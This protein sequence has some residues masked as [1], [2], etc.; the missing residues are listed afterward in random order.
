M[1]L[2]TLHRF[3]T[4]P[5]AAIAFVLA[6]PPVW[7]QIEEIVI[8]AR[9]QEERLQDVPIAVAAFTSEQLEERGARDMY[10]VTRFTP[11]FSFEK[12]NRYGVQ[13]GVSRPVIRGMSNILGEGN[14][15][16]FVDGIPYSDSILSFPFDIAERVE[17][18]KG[19]QAA[20]FGRATFSGAINLIT[21]KGGNKP[22]HTVSAR[23]AEYGDTELNLLSRGPLIDDKLF[24]MVH[25]RYYTM[26]GMY[27]NSLDGGRI[28]GEESNN[29]NASLEWRPRDGISAILSGGYTRDRDDLAAVTLQERF[30]NNCHLD[31]PRQYYCGAV[32]VAPAG[33]L[34]RAGLQGT[35]GLHR[36]ST[37]LSLQLTFDLPAGLTLVSNSGLFS[38]Q[39]EYGYDSTYQGATALGQT[40]VPGAPGYVRP[41][42][43][44][45]RNGGVMRNEVTDRDEWSTELRLQSDPTQRLSYM[46]GAYYYKSQRSLEE[47]HFLATAPTVF[48]G[49][50][51]VENLAAFASVDFD[52][53]DRWSATAELRYA[54]DTIGNDNAV[55]RP[56]SPLV[57]NTFDSVSPR[58][59]TTFKF[60]PENMVYANIA[61]GNKPGVINPDPRFPES[62]RFA[63]EEESWNYEIGTKNRFLNGGLMVNLSLYYIDWTNQQI[64]ASYTFPPP[65]GGT[66]SYIRNAGATEIKGAELEVEAAL[67]DNFTTGFTYSL[68]D[69]KFTS[70][71]DNEA[72]ELFGNASLKGNKLFGVPEQQASAYGKFTFAAGADRT[73]FVRG[74][75]SFTD[76]KFDQIFD[77]AHTGEQI[78]SN[79]SAGVENDH[80][81]LTF[82]VNN[83]FDDRTPS[84]VTRYVDQLNRNIPQYTNAN[85][86]QNNVPGSTTL[87]RAF[88]YP[89]PNKRQFGMTVKWKF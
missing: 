20:L 4:L 28:G 27:R 70:L 33:K 9:K 65:T 30:A 71:T 59:T 14:A 57:E 80:L 56:T 35:E 68:T 21:K 42:S 1:Q 55:A 48:S 82:F 85:P 78:L 77:L 74:D 29:F 45:V 22:E 34:D 38:T 64:T 18:I 32:Q 17:V 19:P 5:L 15:Q 46:I 86:A 89:L 54:E 16:V 13:G 79:L 2:P 69:A 52:F 84:S 76:R 36:D 67:T 63:D 31:A 43:D 41:L 39:M 62:I 6:S 40:T 58:V 72:L 25:G 7:S 10:D 51:Q 75:L 8:T 49:E 53:T 61:Q 50:T 87:E 11:G 37:R 44:P 66:Q 47:R 3:A 12:T 81:A 88:Y 24:Y 60:T 83:L 73:G 26:D 23:L